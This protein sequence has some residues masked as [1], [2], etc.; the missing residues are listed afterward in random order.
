MTPQN[1][2]PIPG[3]PIGAQSALDRLRAA[4]VDIR[5]V[6]DGY[7]ETVYEQSLQVSH[8][9]GLNEAGRA[10]RMR[11][12]REQAGQRAASDLAVIRPRLDED[13][14][15]VR[16]NLE[17]RWPS[18]A[19]GLEALMAR[20]ASWSRS[21]SLLEAGVG[22][23]ALVDELTD[24]EALF[25]LREELPMW[26]RANG[27]RLQSRPVPVTVVDQ[28]IAALSGDYASAALEGVRQAEAARAYCEPLLKHAEREV[29]GMIDLASTLDAAVSANIARQRSLAG[30]DAA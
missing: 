9:T 27:P 17:R 3:L 29:G 28:R 16:R 6:V 22:P 30:D 19:A 15:T 1:P 21:R 23:A 2:E 26:Q 7:R 14:A 20:Q 5:A 11:Q 4:P 25:A 12:I 18:P 8:D 13:L 10:A 24:V